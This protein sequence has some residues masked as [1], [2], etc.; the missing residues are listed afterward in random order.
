VSHG[1]ATSIIR[2]HSKEPEPDAERYDVGIPL[3]TLADGK[4]LIGVT[5]VSRGRS[6]VIHRAAH[7]ANMFLMD[8]L[9]E[10]SIDGFLQDHEDI[11]LTA[12]NGR[13]L[14]SQP[15]IE[16]QVPSPDPDEIALS[17]D[18]LMQKEDGSW[19]VWDLK[20]PLLRRT[21][22]TVGPRKRRRFVHSIEDG[23]AQL[24]HY[25]EFF[26]ITQNRIKL[27]EMNGVELGTPSYGLVVGT[28]ENMDK[29]KIA[30][31]SRRLQ[32]FELIDYD[33]LLQL[34]LAGNN[35]LQPDPTDDAGDG[36]DIAGA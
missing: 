12:L 26:E 18:L 22:A 19:A 33:S 24:A 15:L 14:V 5:C 29:T 28:Y 8:K 4:P 9:H 34:Y 32:N 23:I 1:S 6:E 16:W 30:E 11:L 20:L 3:F 17:P 27:R 31:A 13:R 36:L 7:F 35:A 25:K 10:T 2:T 21:D